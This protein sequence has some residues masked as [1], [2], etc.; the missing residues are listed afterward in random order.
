MSG[1]LSMLL[2]HPLRDKNGTGR[3]SSRRLEERGRSR[4]RE[5]GGSERPRKRRRSRSR[6]HSRRRG[7][8]G[9]PPG[10]ARHGSKKRR[11]RSRSPRKEERRRRV[12]SPSG[13]KS[14]QRG[15]SPA[16]RERASHC[17]PRKVGG[18]AGWRGEGLL[19]RM[20][21]KAGIQMAAEQGSR[22]LGSQNR[23]PRAPLHCS[24]PARRR[25]TWRHCPG[26]VAAA[27]VRPWQGR[28]QIHGWRQ[29][30]PAASPCQRSW[31]SRRSR[32]RACSALPAARPCELLARA[33]GR[34]AT[35]AGLAR[36][37]LA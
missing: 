5:R 21:A 33:G 31:H 36:P 26:A 7:K 11:S 3:E 37:Q 14:G 19:A 24:T 9:S 25:R 18:T 1:L 22:K 16:K 4:S 15:R 20:Q 13:H 35:P 2:P 6:S 12:S 32:S 28:R 29:P 30:L 27:A 34:C 23:V 8:A 10:S 17:P